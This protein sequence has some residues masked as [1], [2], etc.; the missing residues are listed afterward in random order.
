MKYFLYGGCSLEAGGKNYMISLEPVCEAL[1]MEFVEIDDWNCCGAS[2]SYA[3]ANELS[4][5]TLN[6]RNIAIAESTGGYDIV[7]P[8]S[9]CY[10][11]MIKANHELKESEDLRKQINDILKEGN[12]SFKGT[13]NVRHIMDLLYNDAG[14][15]NIKTK[16]Q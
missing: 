4:I 13:L 1:G 15:E 12:L 16:T 14:I 7:A 11:Q 8:C 9:S 5:T 2:V 10:I 3:G 6:A